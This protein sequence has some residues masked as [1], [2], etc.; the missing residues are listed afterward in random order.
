MV[1][2]W[3]GLCEFRVRTSVKVFHREIFRM[4]HEGTKKRANWFLTSSC[5]R[6]FVV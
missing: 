2:M 6:D 3:L 5:R 1:S 4:N